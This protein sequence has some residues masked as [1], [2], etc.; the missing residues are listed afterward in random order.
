MMNW[1]ALAVIAGLTL[2]LNACSSTPTPQAAPAGDA[3]KGDA[4]KKD[5]DAMKKDGDAMKKDGDAMKGDAM[6]KDGDAMK[7]DAMKKEGDAMKK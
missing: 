6:K 2:T 4:M 3:M 5:G 7:G 1:K